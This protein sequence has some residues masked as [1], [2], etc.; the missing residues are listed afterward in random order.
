VPSGQSVHV[1]E[2]GLPLKV[3]RGHVDEFI[4]FDGQEVPE[5]QYIAQ[6]L[7]CSCQDAA[8]VHSITLRFTTP[9]VETNTAASY[10][11]PFISCPLSSLPPIHNVQTAVEGDAT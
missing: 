2:N 3:P 10:I 1:A 6:A 9:V 7:I 11:F 4:K 5:G 8:I